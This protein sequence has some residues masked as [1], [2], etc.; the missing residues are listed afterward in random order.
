[1]HSSEVLHEFQSS[2]FVSFEPFDFVL[3]ALVFGISHFS[4][5]I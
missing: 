2:F 3:S 4:D 5:K 1:M